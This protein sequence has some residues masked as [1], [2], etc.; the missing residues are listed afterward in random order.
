MFFF[1]IIDG[2][3]LLDL[4]I[5]CVKFSLEKQLNSKRF[6]FGRIALEHFKSR[7][8]D[9]QAYFQSL[10][11]IESLREKAPEFL[12]EIKNVFIFFNKNI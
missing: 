9:F 12:L 2:S 5:N 8:C 1:R 3:P 10:F 4:A 6:E 11:S 7:V